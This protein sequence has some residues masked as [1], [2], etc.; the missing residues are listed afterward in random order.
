M[1][2]LTPTVSQLIK[3]NYRSQNSSVL[4]DTTPVTPL[5]QPCHFQ[6]NLE[7]LGERHA[8]RCRLASILPKCLNVEIFCNCREINKNEGDIKLMNPSNALF[9]VAMLHAEILNKEFNRCPNQINILKNIINICVEETNK[10]SDW[11]DSTS[12]CATH[13]REILKLFL[14]SLLKDNCKMYTTKK[15]FNKF[16]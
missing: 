13:R 9:E 10:R 11:F 14:E 4:C 6:G 12:P 3:E 7:N 15:M 2:I 16:Q 5:V 8:L 1:G